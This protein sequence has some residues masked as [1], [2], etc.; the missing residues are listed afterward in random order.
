[1]MPDRY[2]IKTTPIGEM[3]LGQL[4]AEAEE[5]SAEIRTTEAELGKR[6]S[7][8]DAG[9]AAPDYPNWLP[10]AKAYLHRLTARYIPIKAR[11]KLLDGDSLSKR[12]VTREEV[13]DLVNQAVTDAIARLLKPTT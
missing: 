7:Q 2:V 13:K 3:T 1:M 12:F 4:R 10:R 6:K 9:T 8:Y 11:I 5:L